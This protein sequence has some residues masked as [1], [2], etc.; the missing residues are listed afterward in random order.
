M[1]SYDQYKAAADLIGCEPE[2]IEAVVQK[3][4]GKTSSTFSAGGKTRLKILFERHVFWREL[5]KRGV[6]PRTLVR[7]DPTLADILSQQPY[8]TYGRF[9][10]QYT[11]RDR[12]STINQEAA[13]AACS[14]SAFQI[15]GNNHVACGY[16]TV[17]SFVDAMEQG[18][19]ETYLDAFVAFVQANKI[20]T[21]LQ[22][23][24]FEGFAARYNGPSYY[25][26]GYHIKLARIYQRII[27]RNLPRH[28]SKLAAVVQSGTLQRTGAAVT[29]AAA[30]AAPLLLE[31]GNIT[32]LLSNVQAV[33]D[34]GKAV[35]ASV[36]DL[37]QQA[38]VIT[39]SLGWVE[40]LPWLAGGWSVLLLLIFA[41]VAQR[42]LR[43]RGYV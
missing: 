41:A 19:A 42:Y 31:G 1:F 38:Q 12:A 7:R 17:Q 22:A 37:H 2:I 43:D 18:D 25:K 29:A 10:D 14:Y 4:V 32:D 27:A 6:D 21:F 5:E 34:Q 8:G 20:D 15:M 24:D 11:R 30:P 9:A 3:E 35:A 40:W 13:L 36:G 23:R 39:E 16:D 33:A 28:E 26:R